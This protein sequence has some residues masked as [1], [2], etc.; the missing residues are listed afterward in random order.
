MA[1]SEPFI[2][3]LNLNSLLGKRLDVKRGICENFLGPGVSQFINSLSALLDSQT[4]EI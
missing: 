4:T 1:L 2:N 3:V